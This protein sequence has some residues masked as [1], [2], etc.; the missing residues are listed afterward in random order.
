MIKRASALILVQLL[1]AAAGAETIVLKADRYLDVVAG[2]H[3]A[4]AVIVVEG[5]RIV[6]VNPAAAPAGARVIELPGHTL[7][8]GLMDAHV[9][10]NYE[11]IAGWE[12]EPVRLT[13][14]DFALRGVPNARKTLLAGFTTVRDVGTGYGFSDVALMR[15]IDAG[16]VPG[17][18]IIPAA[19]AIST[20][21]G[22]CDPSTGLAPGIEP[23]N[24]LS[25]VAD[26]VD[27]VVK[28]IR[29]QVK[30]GA[31]VIKIC[32]TAGVLSFEGPVGAQQYSDQELRAAAEE[33]HRHG[34]RIAAHAHGT[35]GIIA[36]SRAGID[37]IEHNSIMTEEAAKVLKENG[38]FVVPNL[39]LIEAIDV[40]TL[41]PAL[42]AKQ[43]T[44]IPRVSESFRRSLAHGLKVAF[45][46]DAGVFPH[47][48]NAKEFTA[49]VHYGDTPLHAI[50]SATLVAAELFGTPD[51]GRIEPGLLADLVAVAGDPLA[52]IR[53]LEDVRFVMKD[54]VVYKQPE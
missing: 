49:R 50:R 3:V 7:L 45:G 53:L 14:G 30:H 47:G 4:P 43:T 10:L 32:A 46:T 41:P 42:A 23:P 1:A 9:H 40:T 36:S 39:Y 2:R 33:A 37:S 20:L 38:T 34:L 16:W 13:T 6:A 28:A 27:E 8:P 54:G 21:G 17:P 52:D 18:R 5:A 26:G 51:R 22:H 11:L 25:G 48:L 12:T 35:E 15:A 44:L 31:K 19:H 29:H 24:Y